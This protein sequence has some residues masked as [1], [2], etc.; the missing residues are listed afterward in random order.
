MTPDPE[1]KLRDVLTTIDKHYAQAWSATP[2]ESRC[3][4]INR[5]DVAA[6]VDEIERLR[7]RVD[8]LESLL[9]RWQQYAS[10]CHCCAMSG[11]SK[12]D[13]YSTFTKHMRLAALLRSEP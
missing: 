2:L 6:A 7:R 1:Q 3:H 10:Y 11:E 12:L 9:Q 8:E 4:W 13:D 5:V